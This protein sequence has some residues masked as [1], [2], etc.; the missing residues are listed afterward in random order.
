MEIKRV[1]KEK[2]KEQKLVK[3]HCVDLAEPPHPALR[4]LEEGP[5]EWFAARQTNKTA[6]LKHGLKHREFSQGNIRRVF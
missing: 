6:D 5:T 1:I 4:R 3:A 2:R